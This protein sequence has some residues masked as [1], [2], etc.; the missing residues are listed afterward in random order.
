VYLTAGAARREID[1]YVRLAEADR[2]EWATTSEK[3]GDSSPPALDALRRMASS[4]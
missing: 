2:L 1:A 4:G 3:S